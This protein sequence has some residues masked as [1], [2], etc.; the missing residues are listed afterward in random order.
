MKKIQERAIQL[1]PSL[2]YDNKTP[3]LIP[4][5]I[6]QLNQA[7]DNMCLLVGDQLQVKLNA[8]SNLLTLANQPIDYLADLV[9]KQLTAVKQT[10]TKAQELFT[11]MKAFT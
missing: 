8:R 2:V 7:A 4:D 11:P 1:S 5:V 9:Y 3:P 6:S 10:E